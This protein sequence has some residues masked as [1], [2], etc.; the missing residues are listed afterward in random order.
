MANELYR[1]AGA[2]S[3]HPL[4][5]TLGQTIQASMQA[6]MHNHSQQH[7]SVGLAQACLGGVLDSPE[8]YLSY[9]HT[10]SPFL[11]VP[12]LTAMLGSRVRP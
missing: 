12:L 7:S 11:S 4:N 3:R 6:L 2:I 1:M 5:E 10:Q 9:L 8:G